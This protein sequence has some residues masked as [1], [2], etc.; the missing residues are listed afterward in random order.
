[1]RP[2]FQPGWKSWPDFQPGW[3]SISSQPVGKTVSSPCEPR[4]FCRR[5]EIETGFQFP[6]HVNRG[7]RSHAGISTGFFAFRI[8]SHRIPSHRIP[9]HRIASHRIASHR[10]ASH[11]IASHR[12][13]S[14]RIASHRIP[15]HRIALSHR[16]SCLTSPR[17]QFGPT[18]A[19]PY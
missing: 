11:R 3:K 16:M 1:M 19:G 6:A 4:R 9:S 10:I 15:S 7:L 2:Y 18:A 17:P 12:I 8:A 5:L 14:H 13:A